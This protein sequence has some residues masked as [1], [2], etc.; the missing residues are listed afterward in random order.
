VTGTRFPE[1]YIHSLGDGS[2]T[3]TDESSSPSTIDRL[4]FLDVTATDVAFSQNA[5]GDLVITLSNGETVTI[6]DHFAS[7]HY[8]MEEIAFADGTVYTP[9][10][11]LNLI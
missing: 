2:Y 10:D 6:T 11:I 4:T 3:I 5:G 7:T 1:N 9:D 8:D